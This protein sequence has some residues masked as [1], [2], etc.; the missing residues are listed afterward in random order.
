MHD[1]SLVENLFRKV[2]LPFEPPTSGLIALAQG[3][4]YFI[5]R[6]MLQIRDPISE[7]HDFPGFMKTCEESFST[8]LAN[9]EIFAVPA[10]ENVQVLFFGVRGA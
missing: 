10:L 1:M 6:D 5:M 4:L 2:Y 3:L 7:R 8:A 9:F